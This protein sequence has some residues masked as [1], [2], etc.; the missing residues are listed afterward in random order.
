MSHLFYNRNRTFNRL[1]WFFWNYFQDASMPTAGNLFLLV[2]SMPALESFRSIRFAWKR[3]ISRLTDKSLNSF[4]YTLGY[5]AFDRL[6][7]IAATAR[8]A[9]GCIPPSLKGSAVFLSI[10]DTMA[11]KY[12]T[13]FQARSKLFDH[14]A[15]NGS[16]Y[17]NGHCFVSIMLHVP[18]ES[19]GGAI[20]L[21]VPL[22]CRLW[23]KEVSK[24]ELAADMVRSVM[25][26]LSS[27]GQ[28]ILLCG[29]L[30]SREACHRACGRVRKSGNDLLRKVGYSA[31]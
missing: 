11:E 25:T 29:Q 1:F 9:S 5:A 10:D 4:Y 20:Y 7:W 13:K 19:E 27:R 31:L 30:V 18:A 12:G 22:G 24:L 26:E 6:R 3:I 2:I 15:H 16:N 8:L 28:V 17:L 23:T 21:S 14:A